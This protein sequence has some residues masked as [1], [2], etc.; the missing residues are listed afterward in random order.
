M[1]HIHRRGLLDTSVVVDLAM[2]SEVDLPTES[3]I[4]TLTLSELGAGPHATKDPA[5]R[6]RRQAVLQRAEVTFDPLP[7]DRRSAESYAQI[8]AAVRNA[9]RQ[10]RGRA[11][12][13]LI[14]AVALAHRLPLLPPQCTAP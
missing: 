11:V 4:C 5:E 9:G 14:A 8:Y 2:L 3:A 7:F 6:A 1:T 13:L 10:V 12:D